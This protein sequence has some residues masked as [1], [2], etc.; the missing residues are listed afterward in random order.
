MHNNKPLSHGLVQKLNSI[1]E[2]NSLLQ[3]QVMQ[4]KEP[5]IIDD[6]LANLIKEYDD[7]VLVDPELQQYVLQ[8]YKHQAKRY[9]A[10]NV[11]NMAQ[12]TIDIAVALDDQWRK[13]P[14][15]QSARETLL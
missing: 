7:Y 6:L 4:Q 15:Y 10:N 5:G 3:Q 2:K 9:R 14:D 13:T 1:K 11:L 12:A 8:A